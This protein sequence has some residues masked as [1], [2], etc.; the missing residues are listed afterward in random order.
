MAAKRRSIPE[1]SIWTAG[2]Q[3]QSWAGGLPLFFSP[4]GVSANKVAIMKMAAAGAARFP[5]RLLLVLSSLDFNRVI[6]VREI[7]LQTL[8][9]AILRTIGRSKSMASLPSPCHFRHLENCTKVGSCDTCPK[10][11]MAHLQDSQ[12][13]AKSGKRNN[14]SSSPSRQYSD[15]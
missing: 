13:S 10:N 12:V 7:P 2:E 4:L 3:S 1:H 9:V 11:E 14:P 15:S 8:S 5:V 6:P